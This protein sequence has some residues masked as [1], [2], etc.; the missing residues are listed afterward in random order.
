MRSIGPFVPRP[1]P[2]TIEPPARKKRN[3][4]LTPTQPFASLARKLNKYVETLLTVTPLTNPRK[5]V[6]TPPL[7][8]ESPF[9]HTHT[10]THT[11]THTPLEKK[12]KNVL[13]WVRAS[14]PVLVLLGSKTLL[15]RM[16]TGGP[17]CRCCGGK[18][19]RQRSPPLPDFCLRLRP[20]SFAKTIALNVGRYL[21]SMTVHGSLFMSLPQRKT[22]EIKLILNLRC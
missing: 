6:E 18:S 19:N 21:R 1:H 3:C 9:A 15:Y 7:T 14:V 22:T 4:M 2:L 12:R 13:S 8:H 5:Y 11:L 10:H 17:H 20:S 16:R